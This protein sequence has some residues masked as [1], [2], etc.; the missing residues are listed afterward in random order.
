MAT[1][2]DIAIYGGAAG[3]GKT[4]AILAE[5]LRHIHK[6]GFGSVI[7][8]K[9]LIQV[10]NEG[11]LWDEADRLYPAFGAASRKQPLSWVFPQN[12]KIT[13]GHLEDEKTVHNYQG[14][15]IPLIEFDELTHFSQNQFFYMLSRNRSLCGVKPYVRAT[16]NPDADSWVAGFISWW[17]DPDTGLAIPERSGKIRWMIRLN[18]KII[19]ADSPDDLKRD[20]GDE[21]LPKSVTFIASSLF[22]NKILMAADPGYLA[23]LKALSVVERERLLYGNWKIRPTGGLLFRREWITAAPAAPADLQTVRY[24]DLAATEKTDA[25]DPDFTVSVKMGRDKEGRFFLLHGLSLRKS[26]FHV[27]QAVANM[28]GQDGRK[29]IVGL[30]QDPGQAGKSQ[31]QN[32]VRKL[33]GYRVKTRPESGDKIARFGPFSAQCEAGNVYFI[34]GDWNEEF[35]DQLEGFPEAA[36]DDHADACA[37]AFNLLNGERPPMRISPRA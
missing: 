2:A 32:F 8:R 28:A 29:V 34:K 18:D 10:T 5:P 6:K 7:F 21:S 30:P 3:G 14:A 37:G 20:Y 25:N 12:T 17:I 23:N 31:A 22:D 9:N 1:P 35:F 11:G 24:W 19:W 15:Q 16:C 13:F 36:H 27:E 26:P 33:A 4:W